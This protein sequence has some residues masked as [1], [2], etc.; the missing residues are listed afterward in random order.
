MMY[1]YS[2]WHGGG[3]IL[4]LIVIVFPLWKIVTRAGFHGAW[5]LLA[6]VPLVNVIALWVF[7]FGAWPKDRGGA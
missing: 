3:M 5:S 7:A 1:A 6:L 4:M 2:G